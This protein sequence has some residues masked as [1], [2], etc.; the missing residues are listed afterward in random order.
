[1]F[2]FEGTS[3]QRIDTFLLFPYQEEHFSAVVNMGRST[4]DMDDDSQ[5][6]LAQALQ[7]KVTK[8]TLCS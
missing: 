1:V 4:I 7:E 6:V 3:G 2:L 8:N 5:K